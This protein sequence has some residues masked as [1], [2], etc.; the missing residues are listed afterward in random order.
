MTANCYRGWQNRDKARPD[1]SKWSLIYEKTSGEK[2]NLI[3]TRAVGYKKYWSGGIVDR[4]RDKFS[5]WSHW[6][7]KPPPAC[8]TAKSVNNGGQKKYSL[9]RKKYTAA[10][11]AY[12]TIGARYWNWS[13][14]IQKP[15]HHKRRARTN[16]PLLWWAFENFVNWDKFKRMPLLRIRGPL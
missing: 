5:K 8:P 3:K 14:F 13:E 7:E 12:T 2:V 15:A 10:N 9:E 11:I 16:S 1:I 6:I 4:K